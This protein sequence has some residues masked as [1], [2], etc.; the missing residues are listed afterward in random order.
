MAIYSSVTEAIGNTPLI[1]L[2]RIA[3]A[4]SEVYVKVE[5][6][7]PGGSIKDRAV[8]SMINDAEAR[9]QLKKGGVIIEPTSGNTGIAIAMVAAARGYKAILVMPDTMSK[10][11]QAYLKAYGAELVLTP[12]KLGMQGT[13]DKTK[14]LL[15]STPGSIS[16]G[17]FD[18]P[19]NI[20][21]H[22]A[23]TG[24]EILADL[25]DVDYVVAGFGTGGTISGIAWALRDAGSDAKT[26]A[27]EPAES[28]LITEGHA[29]PHKIQGIGAN[30]VPA[31]LDRSVVTEVSTVKG[32]DAIDTARALAR[33]EGIFA[34]ISSGANV[35]KAIEITKAHPGS[36]VVAILPDGGDKYVSTGIYE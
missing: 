36:K 11:R 10:E 15:A 20:L 18:N 14:E 24:R 33:Q 35:F 25:P 3:P 13:L 9:G 28:P 34:G 21:A 26:V 12:G 32:Q 19:A 16:L 2:N 29:G 22:R 8:L 17:Q 4:G 5:G 7:N 31:N 27:V 6:K 1:R 30:F 23:S